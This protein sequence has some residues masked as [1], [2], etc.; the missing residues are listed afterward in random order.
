MNDLEECIVYPVDEMRYHFPCRSEMFWIP[1]LAYFSIA[2]LNL[3]LWIPNFCIAHI[4]H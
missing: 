1:P 2:D 4:F 3:E